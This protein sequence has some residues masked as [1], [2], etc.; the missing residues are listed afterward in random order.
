MVGLFVFTSLL[1]TRLLAVTVAVGVAFWLVRWLAMGKFS[2]RTPADWGILLLTLMAGVSCL[3]TALPGTTIPQVLRLLTGVL[4]FYA[5][6]NW[7]RAI[8]RSDWLL[9]ILALAGLSLSVFALV[10]VDW[11]VTKLPFVPENI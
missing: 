4:L 10:S 11:A 7:T 3:I 9:S 6:V 5:V 8:E 2:I 1:W